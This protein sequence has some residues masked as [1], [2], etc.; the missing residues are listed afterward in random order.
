MEL[1]TKDQRM[2]R[3]QIQA[4]KK[5]LL[6][7]HAKLG[8]LLKVCEDCGHIP[9]KVSVGDTHWMKCAVCGKDLGWWCPKSPTN[10]CDY[11]HPIPNTEFVD[12]DADECFYC[13]QP[14][15]RK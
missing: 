4:A 3:N 9:D 2:L 14:D 12:Y 15:E 8:R 6:D 1:K 13:G 7:S 11:H 5:A 10:I